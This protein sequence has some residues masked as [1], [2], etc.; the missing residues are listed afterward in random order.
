MTSNWWSNL[1]FGWVTDCYRLLEQV[2]KYSHDVFADCVLSD[3]LIKHYPHQCVEHLGAQYFAWVLVRLVHG[4]RHAERWPRT[5]TTTYPPYL[6]RTAIHTLLLLICLQPLFTAYS[7]SS[8]HRLDIINLKIL[9][10]VVSCDT[11][12]KIVQTMYIDNQNII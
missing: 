10:L 12:I 4:P 5:R 9:H 1:V 8:I 3:R 2:D 6:L 11:I 7:I